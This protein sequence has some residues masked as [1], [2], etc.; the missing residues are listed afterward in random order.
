MPPVG[1]RHPV[2][3][4]I[5]SPQPEFRRSFRRSQHSRSGRR[6][7]GT[8]A[9]PLTV[10]RNHRGAKQCRRMR[11]RRNKSPHARNCRASV[12]LKSGMGGS[13]RNRAVRGRASFMANKV[14]RQTG[15]IM[16]EGR[17]SRFGGAVGVGE[18]PVVEEAGARLDGGES[19]KPLRANKV[20]LSVKGLAVRNS[21]SADPVGFLPA[22][23]RRRRGSIKPPPAIR[24]LIRAF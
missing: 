13:F 10:L 2:P 11:R 21:C 16:A 20:V 9:R 17:R 19:Q 1:K 6:R 3:P 22:N 23:R 4:C 14:L 24:G 18:L 7:I 12:S 15:L 5:R 8:R